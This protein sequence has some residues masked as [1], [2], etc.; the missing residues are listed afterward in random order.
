M[1]SEALF[2]RC[3]IGLLLALLDLLLVSL[4]LL[5]GWL[6]LLLLGA[7][8]RG[9][10]IIVVDVVIVDYI[11]NQRLILLLPLLLLSR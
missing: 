1:L 5:L 2:S 9:L 10:N 3:L 8:L 6:R 7:R 11:G 4:R